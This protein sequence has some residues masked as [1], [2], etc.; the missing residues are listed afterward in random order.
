[1]RE[2]RK[3]SLLR[4]GFLMDRDVSKAAEFFPPKRT[5]TIAE[6][7]L[8][9]NASDKEIVVKAWELELTIVTSN[10]DDFL[11]ELENFSAQTK[12]KALQAI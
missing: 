7:G 12:K 11:R 1:M 8:A 6:V 5:R 4:Y 2:K 3:E 9:E 10:G